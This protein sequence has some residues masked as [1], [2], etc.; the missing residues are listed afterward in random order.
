[1]GG[2]LRDLLI[3]WFP[4][5]LQSRT[6]LLLSV[7]NRSQL[8][9]YQSIFVRNDFQLEQFKTRISTKTP[10]VFDIGAN[11]GFFSMRVMDEF[12]NAFV[13]AFEP[14]KELTESFES[15]IAENNLRDKISVHHCAL[16]REDG[17]AIL[18]QNRSP[19]SA[20]VIKAKV[21]KRS[22]VG[23][24]SVSLRS[25][26]GYVKEKAIDH[27][28]ILKI[29]VEGSEMDVIAGADEILG[30]TG[31]VLVEIH[32]PF[33]DLEGVSN[34]LKKFNLERCISLERGNNVDLVFV[35]KSATISGAE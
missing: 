15:V 33:S 17:E 30:R 9:L 23:Q 12:P 20:S 5:R 18:Y 31:L 2:H 29:D 19:I 25:L 27:I 35:S 32:A 22:V 8:Q 34:A 24:Q 7:S 11:C 28:D 6:G 16:G 3:A 1:M 26:N 21:A 10:I 14:Q 13:H 4:L